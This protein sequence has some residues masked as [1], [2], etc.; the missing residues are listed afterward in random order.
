MKPRFTKKER[1][2]VLEEALRLIRK[3]HSFVQSN[4]KCQAIKRDPETGTP[5]IDFV[6][7]K[8]QPILV[9]GKPIYS[10]CVEGAVNEATVTVLGVERAWKLGACNKRGQVKEDGNLADNLSINVVARELFGD[11][12]AEWGYSAD[13][14]SARHVNDGYKWGDSHK[15]VLKILRKKIKELKKVTAVA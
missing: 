9:N 15:A 13:S 7:G 2:A 14:C 10:Y 6:T 5:V 11:D 1:L 12:L 8:Y 3:P 4:W